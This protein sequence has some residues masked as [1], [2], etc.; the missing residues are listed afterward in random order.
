MWQISH[1]IENLTI[2]F[3][4]AY[5]TAYE[6]IGKEPGIDASYQKSENFKFIWLLDATKKTLER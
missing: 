3:N 2:L 4:K 1:G 5:K 6:W